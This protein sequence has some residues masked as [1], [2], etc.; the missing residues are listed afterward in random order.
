MLTWCSVKCLLYSNSFNPHNHP[1]RS[2]LLLAIFSSWNN[3]GQRGQVAVITLPTKLEGQTTRGNIRKWAPEWKIRT[4][5]PLPDLGL[6]ND[7]A[8]TWP[9]ALLVNSRVRIWTRAVWLQS[10][11]FT[12]KAYGYLKSDSTKAWNPGLPTS[13][14]SF[15]QPPDLSY[16]S[17][18][19]CQLC[20]MA[21]AISSSPQ[22]KNKKRESSPFLP[23]HDWEEIELL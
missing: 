11:F 8:G 5:W 19:I 10:V 15:Q 9:Q 2:I 17:H 23:S 6:G 21:L 20:L 7:R 16:N 3:G 14:Y 22:Y 12:P 4:W 1:I 13:N 18:M